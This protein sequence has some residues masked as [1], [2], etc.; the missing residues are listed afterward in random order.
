MQIMTRAQA[1]AAGQRT[2][3]TG[4]PCKN[5]HISTRYT[6]TSLCH[7]CANMRQKEMRQKFMM[8]SQ[9]AENI[10]VKMHPGDRMQVQEFATMLAATRGMVIYGVPTSVR[11]PKC[12]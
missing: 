10:V 11:Q 1:L 5:G 9:G 4:K 7:G 12:E 8:A 2:Y 3:F 6:A